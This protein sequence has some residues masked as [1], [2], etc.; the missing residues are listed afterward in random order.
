MGSIDF[1]CLSET[2]IQS[3]HECNLRLENYKL[4]ANYSRSNKK[5]GGTC[6]LV[7]DDLAFSPL[8]ITNEI[9]SDYS[10][11]CC[12]IEVP[13]HNL[14]LVCVYRIPDSDAGIFLKKIEILLHKLTH[15]SRNRIIICG[16]WNIDMLKDTTQTRELVTVLNNFNLVTHIK[17]PTRKKTCID[18]IASN[19]STPDTKSGIHNLA[20]S[21]HDT[22][23]TL[24]FCLTVANN[25]PTVP[26][27]FY[28]VK[29]DYNKD[30]IKKILIVYRL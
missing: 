19:I 24:T 17:M 13:S 25:K 27:F 4:A 9:S 12:G 26:N 16:D 21:D 28:E 2:F 8:Q 20:L 30:N 14:I 5:R 18:Q 11:E 7:K 15:R 29:R 10:F 1:I 3:G 23:Q 6:I 22:G